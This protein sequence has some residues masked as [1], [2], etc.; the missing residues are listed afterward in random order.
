MLRERRGE[1]LEGQV[2]EIPPSPRHAGCVASRDREPLA[3]RRA[4][5]EQ[6]RTTSPPITQLAAECRELLV[7]AQLPRELEEESE[8][9]AFVTSRRFGQQT[10]VV[11][12][13]LVPPDD[14]RQRQRRRRI[15]MRT[16]Q[17]LG[18]DFLEA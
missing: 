11:E 1:A 5:E 8:G 12:A 2:H 17:S 6:P 18:H 16:S 15:V 3:S 10:A 14:E 7:A 13:I 9:L 4:R